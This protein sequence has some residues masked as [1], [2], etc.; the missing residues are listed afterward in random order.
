MSHRTARRYHTRLDRAARPPPTRPPRA[1]RGAARAAPRR[2]RRMRRPSRRMYRSGP[3][4]VTRLVGWLALGIVVA[5]VSGL[6][7]VQM[8]AY[9]DRVTRDESGITTT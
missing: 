5:G 1:S 8:S 2:P 6:G 7:A 9:V 3:H 4:I